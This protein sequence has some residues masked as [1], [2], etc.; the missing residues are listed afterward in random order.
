MKIIRLISENIKRVVAVEIIPQ[1]NVVEVTGRNG[2]GKTSVLDS[3]WWA[4]AGT[5]THQDKPIRD[6]QKEARIELDLGE[7]VVKRSFRLQQDGQRVTTS[8]TVESAQGAR[9]ASPQGMLDELHR[10]LSFDPVKFMK[11]DSKEQTRRL[12]EAC[13]LSLDDF[14]RAHSAYYEARREV[15]RRVKQL[16]ASA[17]NI[18]VTPDTPDT[19]IDVK[20]LL[21]E[22]RFGD[23][24][25]QSRN[26]WIQKRDNLLAEVNQV[27]SNVARYEKRAADLRVEAEGCDEAAIDLKRKADKLE[28]E[29]A[30]LPD[31]APA[32]DPEPVRLSIERAQGLNQAVEE[33]NRRR[34]L[35]QQAVDAENESDL[36]TAKMEDREMMLAEAV[37]NTD[38]SVPGLS[39]SDGEVTLDGQPFEQASDAQQLRVSCAIAMKNNPKLRV[40]RI[41]DGSLMD[42]QSMELLAS[43]AA[44][45]DF[46]VW[47]ERVDSSGQ[48][49]VVIEDGEV[50]RS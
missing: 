42:K 40:L 2:S 32:F 49:G 22:L 23:Q 18:L 5:R 26:A 10:P 46:Q 36:L 4:L 39:V 34:K 43:M 47:I 37:A 12:L 45:H 33:K 30:S 41:R 50:K 15:N 16:K 27:R 21:E 11:L 38:L 25:N 13:G 6:G 44:E 9:F 8:L 14:H 20:L 48:V 1:A 29:V 35:E 28:A 3:I 17:A 7:I 31:V 19:L 24:R